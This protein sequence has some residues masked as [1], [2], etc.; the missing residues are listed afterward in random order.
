[1]VYRADG[2]KFRV[3]WSGLK[4]QSL[5]CLVLDKEG[6]GRTLYL[7]MAGLYRDPTRMPFR[8]PRISLS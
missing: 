6:L 8:R 4:V 2:L 7:V 1:M 3:R 5:G